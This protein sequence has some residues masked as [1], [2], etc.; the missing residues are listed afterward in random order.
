MD[1]ENGRWE[2][3]LTR[4]LVPYVNEIDGKTSE[5]EN[6]T[7]NEQ[8]HEIDNIDQEKSH[9]ETE[10]KYR[11]EYNETNSSNDNKKETIRNRFGRTIHKPKRFT[12]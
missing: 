11:N 7:T 6:K 1:F 10:T 5:D 2:T 12:D 9:E 3:V 4:N 8:T